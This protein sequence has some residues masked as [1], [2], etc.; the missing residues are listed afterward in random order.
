MGETRNSNARITYSNSQD[1]WLLKTLQYMKS[2]PEILEE[3]INH[4][5]AIVE[6]DI[7]MSSDRNAVVNK[8]PELDGHVSVPYRISSDIVKKTHDILSAMKMVSEHT[9]VSFHSRTTEPNYMYFKNGKGCASHV[10]CIGGAQP[11]FI[12]PAC[13]MGNICHEILH[14]LGFHHEHTRMD[15]EKYIT[16]IPHNIMEGMEKNFGVKNGNTFQLPYDLTSILHY[17][18]DFFSATGLPTIV[19]TKNEPAM[20]QRTHMTKLD[21]QRVH[22]LY[23]CD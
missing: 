2:D 20:G 23:N 19:A 13:M 22:N 18:S 4:D 12:G 11:L 17:G 7:I 8:W 3:L 14:A 1:N 6:G 15:R 9:C 10:G 16:I 21:I 5:V